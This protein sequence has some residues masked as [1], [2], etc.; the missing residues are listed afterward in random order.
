MSYEFLDY[1]EDI[2]DEIARIE[3]LLVDLDYE[4]FVADFRNHYAAV[5]ALE[6]IGEATKRL[7]PEVREA[8][9]QIPWRE[10][11]GMRDRI[12]HGYDSVDLRIVWETVTK[13]IPEL[14]GMIAAILAEL[15]NQQ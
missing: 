14:K 8:Y 10:M 12:I 6:I 7:P 3:L 9:S 11:A 5:R 15:D 1:L 2:L 4:Q 13:R